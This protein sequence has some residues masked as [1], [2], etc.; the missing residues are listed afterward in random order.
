MQLTQFTDYSLRVLIYLAR[1]PEPGLATISE[2]A[3]YHQISRNH[4]VKVANSLANQ[5]FII[6]TRGKGGGIQ[7]G[8]PAYTIGVGE[9]IRQTEV[10][11]DL[12]ECFNVPSNQ[13]RLIRDCF[14][15]AMFYEAQRAFLAVMDKYS[16][17]DAA[18]FGVKIDLPTQS[19]VKASSLAHDESD[20]H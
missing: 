8:R 3:E 17:A 7:L 6:T 5:G 4:L 13:C 19:G 2:I 14:L 12:V 1:L 10:N 16:L 15:K 20:N 11:M 9:V 18:R